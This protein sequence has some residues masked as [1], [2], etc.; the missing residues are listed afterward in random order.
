MA[1]ILFVPTNIY[2]HK[3][4]RFYKNSNYCAHFDNTHTKNSNYL[5]SASLSELNLLQALNL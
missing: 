4:L 3:M 2:L 5:L 1:A